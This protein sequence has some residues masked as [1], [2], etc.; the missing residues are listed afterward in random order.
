MAA[1]A[2]GGGS[3]DYIRPPITMPPNGNKSHFLPSSYAAVPAVALKITSIAVPECEV[4]PFKS[5]L[6]DARAVEHSWTKHA[7]P[8]LDKEELTGEDVIAWAAYHASMQPLVED[9]C[10]AQAST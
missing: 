3:G 1:A 6:D 10:D 9:V 8:L 2:N 7:L 5:C 4:Y